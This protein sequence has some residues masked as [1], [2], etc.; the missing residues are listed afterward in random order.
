[1]NGTNIN[2]RSTTLK[3]KQNSN[4]KKLLL[5]AAAAAVLCSLLAAVV[6]CN[7]VRVENGW[8]KMKK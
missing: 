6:F 2:D 4:G 5:L 1:M 8:G 7:V 3:S